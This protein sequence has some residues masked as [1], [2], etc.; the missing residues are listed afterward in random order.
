MWAPGKQHKVLLVFITVKATGSKLFRTY[1][2]KLAAA[3]DLNRIIF[4]KVHLIVTASNYHQAMV[5]LA[6]FRSIYIQF[7]YLTATLLL[8]IQAAFKE[9]NNLV[10]PKVVQV[11]INQYNL[12]YIVY[13]AYRVFKV[14]SL[15]KEGIQRAKNIQE[16]SLLLDQ[17]QDKIILYMHTKEDAAI[18]VELLYYLQYILKSGTAKEKEVLLHTQLTSLEQLYIIATSTLS[19]GFN[20]IYIRLVIHVNKPLSLVDFAQEFSRAG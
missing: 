18:L 4:N 20:Y 16:N 8:I 13:Q 3:Q 6:L 1:T 17:V 10:Y 5:N 14:R 7:I 9:Q 11:L 15:L 2:Y 19:A 12:F